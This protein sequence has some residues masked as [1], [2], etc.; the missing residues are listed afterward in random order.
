MVL[1]VREENVVNLLEELAVAFYTAESQNF[2]TKNATTNNF[3][4]AEA[5]LETTCIFERHTEIWSVTASPLE[6]VM[7]DR[8]RYLIRYG[9][10]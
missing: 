8:Q 1:S 7:E 4:S 5:L 2:Q 3:S 6:K 9:F 10:I